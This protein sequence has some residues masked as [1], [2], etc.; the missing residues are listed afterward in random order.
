MYD[1]D[2]KL[3]VTSAKEIRLWD[4]YDHKEEAPEL[5]TAEQVPEGDEFCVE[6]VFINKNSRCSALFV[7]VTWKYRFILYTGRLEIKFSKEL[8]D[9]NEHVTAAAFNRD[10]S[11]LLVGTSSGKV[12]S[13]NVSDGEIGGNSF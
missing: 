7:L 6:R 9:V 8:E 13:Y 2:D 5:I 3:V 10:S 12:L 4:F 11:I 1:K